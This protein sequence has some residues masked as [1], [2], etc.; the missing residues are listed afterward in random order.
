MCC[1][2]CG[3]VCHDYVRVWDFTVKLGEQ[4]LILYIYIYIPTFLAVL[5]A[6]SPG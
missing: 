3:N 6:D 4:I 1:M 2:P 5:Y